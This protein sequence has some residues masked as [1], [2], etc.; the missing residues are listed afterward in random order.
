MPNVLTREKANGL[1]LPK[2][3]SDYLPLTPLTSQII[4]L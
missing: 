1:Y 2:A 3:R 4:E